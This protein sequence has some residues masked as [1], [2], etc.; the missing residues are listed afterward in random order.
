MIPPVDVA[1]MLAPPGGGARPAQGQR[2]HR[3]QPLCEAG[4]ADGPSI[5]TPHKQHRPLP[6]GRIPS[7][8]GLLCGCGVGSGRGRA[9]LRAGRLHRLHGWGGF[10][11]FSRDGETATPQDIRAASVRSLSL[12]RISKKARMGMVHRTCILFHRAGAKLVKQALENK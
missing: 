7:L 1:A 4:V 2:S 12:R 6:L 10:R 9:Q 11:F 3:R 5:L 8:Q